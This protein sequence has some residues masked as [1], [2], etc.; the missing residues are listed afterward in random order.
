MKGFYV[1]LSLLV[2]LVC[3]M[4]H[5]VFGCVCNN[6][7]QCSD[8]TYCNGVETCHYYYN[9]S[10]NHCEV[11]TNQCVECMSN[12]DCQPGLFCSG[13]QCK[14]DSTSCKDTLYC[15]G[16]E[17]CY[18]S[19]NTYVCKQGIA[20]CPNDGEYCNGVESC[21]EGTDKCKS[22]TNP[23]ADDGLF[24][25]GIEGCNETDNACIHYSNPC[26]AGL[27]CDEKAN[28]CIGCLE[29]K[30][31]A[32]DVYCNGAETCVN[33]VCK[34]GAAPCPKD[35]VYCNGIEVC[36]EN[37]KTCES[38]GNPCMSPLICEETLDTCI[39][40]VSNGDCDDKV[41]CN[42]VET[43]V[44]SVCKS[45]T[46][47][48][49]DD[50][51]FCNG[52][53]GCNEDANQCSNSGN[54]CAEIYTWSMS[55]IGTTGNTN[56]GCNEETDQ[57]AGCLE[58]KDCDD[59][60]TRTIDKCSN[61]NCTHVGCIT[62][63]DCQDPLFCNGYESCEKGICVPGLPP[64]GSDGNFCN[65]IESCD[66][67]NDKCFSTGN[68]CK[69]KGLGNSCEGRYACNNQ[70]QMCVW[71]NGCEDDLFCNGVEYCN[72]ETGECES[73][74]NPCLGLLDRDDFCVSA[75][76]NE[77]EQT[78]EELVM[79]PDDKNFCNGSET[80]NEGAESCISSGDPCVAFGEAIDSK[81][82]TLVCNDDSQ[83]CVKA[84]PSADDGVFCNGEEVCDEVLGNHST[85]NPCTEGY[86]C[87]EEEKQC[88]IPYGDV[89]PVYSMGDGKVDLL[90]YLEELV[91]VLG[92]EAPE[93]W[94]ELRGDVPTG[95]Y[96]FINE[97]KYCA[98]PDG[99]MCLEDLQEIWDR[100]L[101]GEI[102]DE[103]G[104]Q[105]CSE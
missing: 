49:I 16:V 67:V 3:F 74:G 14:C 78:C 94:Q 46:A 68:P 66:E 36:N 72:D 90:D 28:Q 33:S 6:D 96:F 87:K 39:N 17:T 19:G 30:D 103:L 63:T 29:D 105:Y 80:C 24:C 97:A 53:E 83:A 31:C 37:N 21:D 8:G 50:N 5:P 22:G 73:S 9:S 81:C 75:A 35:G 23:C 92:L 102:A 15:N 4:I 40:C 100:A 11:G 104:F 76:C 25:N 89:F 69:I 86:I 77:L 47:P 99:I 1:V 91:L 57:C 79:C 52:K 101:F 60:N 43:C 54:P 58:E 71:Y 95:K 48:C 12:S 51:L 41:Y 27:S 18:H 44:N 55:A 64:C 93:P 82:R 61:G 70:H 84:D 42:G 38:S 88:A 62:N 20:P 59:G 34:P 98:D 13:N 85:G 26:V 45:G 65:G 32:D 56:L 7:S 10:K 2:L